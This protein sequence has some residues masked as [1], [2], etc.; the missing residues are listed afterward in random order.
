MA[1]WSFEQN[2]LS[3]ATTGPQLL[4]EEP[5]A[6]VNAEWFIS[7]NVFDLLFELQKGF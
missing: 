2:L 1:G 6:C 7:V 4:K 5:T 3:H